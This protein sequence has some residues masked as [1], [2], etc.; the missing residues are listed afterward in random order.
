MDGVRNGLADME[1]ISAVEVPLMP[2]SMV[3]P[4]VFRPALQKDALYVAVL[5][6]MLWRS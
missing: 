6:V 4:A 2:R 1:G 5:V 3:S